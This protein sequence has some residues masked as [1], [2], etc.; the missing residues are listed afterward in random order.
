MPLIVINSSIDE[1]FIFLIDLNFFS[2]FD[3]VLGPMPLISSR[4]DFL[5]LS[6][7]FLLCAVIANR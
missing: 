3:L 4:N 1:F 6:F 7:F 5:I 2:K